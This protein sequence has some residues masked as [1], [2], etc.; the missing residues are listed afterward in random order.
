MEYII[1]AVLVVWFSSNGLRLLGK[2]IAVLLC[3]AALA[4]FIRTKNSFASE[5]R[6]ARTMAQ[7]DS[8]EVSDNRVEGY[9]FGKS[10]CLVY[11]ESVEMGYYNTP[12]DEVT[13]F[14]K[15]PIIINDGM[16]STIKFM[17]FG[18]EFGTDICNRCKGKIELF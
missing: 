11:F 3:L 16:S 13:L 10:V 14:L 6:V 9:A 7:I 2:I 5:E 18:E 17:D 1:G 4:G 8:V 12:Y 15:N